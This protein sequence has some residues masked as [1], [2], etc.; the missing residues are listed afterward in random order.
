M[1]RIR[2]LTR[3]G[4]PVPGVGPDVKLTYI[5]DVLGAGS[6]EAFIDVTIPLFVNKH[7]ETPI[8]PTETT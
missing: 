1:R 5:R 7:P 2:T 6:L 3:C 8:P 4:L